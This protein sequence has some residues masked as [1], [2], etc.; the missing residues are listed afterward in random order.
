[1]QST[2][3]KAVLFDYGLTLVTFTFPRRE[4]LGV[5]DAFRPAIGQATAVAVPAAEILMASVLEPLEAALASSEN[6]EVDYLS[7]YR[8]AWRSV[9]L[10]L[11]SDLLYRILDAEQACWDQAVQLMPGAIATLDML[12]ERGITA[13]VVSNAPFPPEMMARQLAGNGVGRRLATAIFSSAIGWRKPAPA[14]Y[15]AAL[16]QLGCAAEEVL[17]VGDRLVEDYLAPRELGM[18]SVLFTPP[19]AQRA[20]SGVDSIGR[21]GDIELWL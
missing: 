18:R 15:Q 21:L 2:S 1:V 6:R 11:P 8:E 3:V 17:F 13:A 5:L 9:E 10:D 16:D 7:V 19:G 12:G 20:P 14:I 4:L